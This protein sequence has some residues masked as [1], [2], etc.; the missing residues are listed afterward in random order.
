MVG[1]KFCQ[2]DAEKLITYLERSLAEEADVNTEKAVIAISDPCQNA[3]LLKRA[4]FQLGRVEQLGV[5]MSRS[6]MRNS[7]R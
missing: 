2:S 6:V 4:K 1:E 7:T 3:M 5:A